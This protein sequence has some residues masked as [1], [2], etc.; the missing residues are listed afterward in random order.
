MLESAIM[1]RFVMFQ[2]TC[3]IIRGWRSLALIWA[4]LLL[5]LSFLSA[6][7]AAPDPNL[8]LVRQAVNAIE[9][10]QWLQ[11]RALAAQASDPVAKKLIT[12]LYLTSGKADPGFG[13][14]AAFLIAHPGWPSRKELVIRS[15]NN[16][17]D[18]MPLQERV[19]WF[20]RFPP[21]TAKGKYLAAAAFLE[22][23]DN[24]T[25]GRL[26]REV[27]RDGGFSGDMEREILRDYGG[28]L[29]R[30]DHIARLDGLL[31]RGQRDAAARM[32]SLVG[33]D[34][35]LLAKA[36]LALRYRAPDVDAALARV[37]NL[38]RNDPGLFY[39][40]VHWRL[41]NG[42]PEQALKLAHHAAGGLRAPQTPVADIW[43]KHQIT[44]ARLA[45]E[46]HDYQT[47]YN[48]VRTHAYQLPDDAA[49][50]AE[51]EWLAGWIALRFQNQP[52]KAFPH[53][54]R[55]FNAVVTPVSRSR[56]AYWAG[57][58]AEAK[59]DRKTADFWYS[60][61]ARYPVSFY[62]QLAAEK[63]GGTVLRA[64]LDNTQRPTEKEL[65]TY[66][67]QELARATHIL[68]D[69]DKTAVA[70]LFFLA[71]LDQSKT[72]QSFRLAA[73][74]A[75]NLQKRDFG[76][77]A[78]KTASRYGV[79]LLEEG[80][81]VISLPRDLGAG[82]GAEIALIL[83]LS[84]QESSFNISAVSPTGAIGLMQLMP[85]TANGVARALKIP[86]QPQRLGTDPVYNLRLG[87]TY[88]NGLLDNYSGSYVMALAAYNAGGSR[89]TNWMAQNGDP[90]QSL[91]R[92]IDWI[93]LIPFSETRNYVQRVMENVGIYRLRLGE[94][95]DPFRLEQDLMR[96]KAARTIQ[97]APPEKP[98][99]KTG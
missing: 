31:W 6:V 76:I 53:F 61:A 20:R 18:T 40:R 43:M 86:Y 99:R 1:K 29:D 34:M 24:K 52:A 11:A 67:Q 17:P 65:N 46:K 22:A 38:L 21:Y 5:S 41:N 14:I 47:A 26:L 82:Q 42:K 81:P 16:L 8:S 3:A 9:R 15:E 93:E 75:S 62:G 66:R 45:L 36:R 59:G 98:S 19:E 48:V 83:A 97:L 49:A 10:G 60:E 32:F 70:K 95:A 78:A 80:Y 23:R 91:D 89:V 55:L 68:I 58:A 30:Q 64:S 37:P 56:G 57:R 7:R 12:Y 71:L 50:Y 73:D 35:E 77:L 33:K 69:L 79:W 74:F 2:P 94:A 88:L 87:T 85:A 28:L 96:G 90:R 84:R 72:P 25:G 92:M 54:T 4:V 63:R 39:E 27:W 13:E 51:A 44:L